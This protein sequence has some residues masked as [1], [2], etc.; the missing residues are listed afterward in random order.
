M[1]T[2]LVDTPQAGPNSSAVGQRR[3]AV[4][5]NFVSGGQVRVNLPVIEFGRCLCV[6][7]RRTV[8]IE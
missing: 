8:D 2:I 3:P 7:K 5:N 6:S 4:T 1:N